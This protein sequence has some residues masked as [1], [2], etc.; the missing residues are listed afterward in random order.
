MVTSRWGASHN[1]RDFNEK[2][3]EWELP[4]GNLTVCELEHH[5]V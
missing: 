1:N 4:S 3:E 5:N 2:V